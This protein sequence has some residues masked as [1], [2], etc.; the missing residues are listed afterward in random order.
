MPPTHGTFRQAARGQSPQAKAAGLC[1]IGV[2]HGTGAISS[3]KHRVLLAV[4]FLAFLVMGA[5]LMMVVVSHDRSTRAL[6]AV[7]VVVLFAMSLQI[8]NDRVG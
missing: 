5:S 8:R 7:V 2:P 1:V 4:E 3:V 6:F